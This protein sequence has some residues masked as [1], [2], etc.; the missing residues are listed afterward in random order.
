MI[1]NIECYQIGECEVPDEMVSILSDPLWEFDNY[2]TCNFG[3]STIAINF[4]KYNPCYNSR[5]PPE[6]P[7][8]LKEVRTKVIEVSE[9]IITDLMPNHTIIKGELF[10][11]RGLKSQNGL[12]N[13]HGHRDSKVMHR[14][15]HRIHIPCITN[16][17]AYLV[18]NDHEYHLPANTIWAFDNITNL[19]YSKNMGQQIRWHIIVD[20]I[21][22]NKLKEVLT[23]ITENEFYGSWPIWSKDLANSQKIIALSL[24][25]EMQLLSGEWET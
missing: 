25:K 17:E 15:S 19:H 2:F 12:I 22:S 4:S 23:T 8:N 13:P 20:V 16:P 9:N 1:E 5:I 3:P 7:D 21:E 18:V 14:F 24:E 11:L 6:L 10:G